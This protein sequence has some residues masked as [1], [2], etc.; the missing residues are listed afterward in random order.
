[1]KKRETTGLIS[2]ASDPRS[3]ILN[4]AF[5]TFAEKGFD[6]SRTREIAASAGV[7]LAMVHYY[8]GSK[9][10]LYVKTV[11]P[12]FIELLDRL[13][14]AVNECSEPVEC[15]SSIVDGYFD[16][17]SKNPD[18][19]RLMMW[20]QV[21]GGRYLEK[22]FKPILFADESRTPARLTQLFQQGIDSKVFIIDSPVQAVIS[23]VA[24]CVFPFAARHMLNFTL[25]VSVNDQDFLE[26]RRQHVK[27][28]LI[29]G[30]TSR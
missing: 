20:E 30:L 17:L 24:L 21:S 13:E 12:V 29:Q 2:D 23:M 5:K 28:L 27:E 22:I 25:P 10:E 9:E 7:N 4:A 15:L 8:F 16:F 6:G 14:S 26:E 18:F 3:R 11:Q 1:L 19:P